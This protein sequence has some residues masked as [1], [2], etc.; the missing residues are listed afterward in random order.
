M[1]DWMLHLVGRVFQQAIFHCEIQVADSQTIEVPD[2]TMV[3][4]HDID[5]KLKAYVEVGNLRFQN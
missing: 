1:V 2:P 3:P 4:H 5:R